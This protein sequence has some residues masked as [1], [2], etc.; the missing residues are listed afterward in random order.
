MDFLEE[1]LRKSYEKADQGNQNWCG[2]PVATGVQK[3]VARS[4]RLGKGYDFLLGPIENQSDSEE[5][6]LTRY[7]KNLG[8]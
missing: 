2:T 4:V 5:D 8:L 7:M 6:Q 1:M 3:R